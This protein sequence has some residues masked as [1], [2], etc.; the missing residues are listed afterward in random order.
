MREYQTAPAWRKLRDALPAPLIAFAKAVFAGGAVA[1]VLLLAYE[2]IELAW[3]RNVPM[4]DLHRYHQVRGVSVALLAAAVAAWQVLRG[5]P[6]LFTDTEAQRAGGGQGIQRKPDQAV[7]YA[8]WFIVMRWIAVIIAAVLVIVAVHVLDYLP[9]DVWWP[10]SFAIGALGMMNL[11]YTVALRL[12]RAAG[13]LLMAQV[14]GDLLVLTVLLHLSGGVEN[15]LSGVMLFHVIIAGIVLQR[16][17]CYMVASVASAL[18]ALLVFA[19]GIALIPHYTLAVFPHYAGEETGGHVIHAAHDAAYALS[20][21]GLQTAMM[22]LTAYFAT[23]MTE[24]LRRGERQLELFADRV[25]AQ[26]QL[27]ERALETTGTALCVCD[28]D[29]RPTWTNERWRALW[30]DDDAG[31]CWATLPAGAD[32][33]RRTL[34]DGKHR[35][36]E[37]GLPQ[38]TGG[39]SGDAGA[40]RRRQSTDT[41]HYLLT[42]APLV[43][44][45]GRITL[46]VALAR[47]ITEQK[48]IQDRILRT[49]KL[50]A[51]GEL[52]GKV[53]HEVNNPIAIISAKAR[54]LLSDHAPDLSPRTAD[55]LRKMT[56]L[57]DRVARIAQGL[58][59]YCR[60]SPGPVAPLD[61]RIPIRKALAIVEPSASAAGIEIVE[62]LP[63]TLPA[64]LV[65]CGEMEQVFL[66]LFVNAL[67][68]MPGGGRLT[69]SARAAGSAGEEP[70][71]LTVEV[72]DTGCGI[73]RDI[74]Q[75][76]F[77]PFLTTKPDGKGTGLG[78]SICLGLVRSNG[79]TIE[80][81]SEPGHGTR[82]LL[83]LPLAPAP[84]AHAIHV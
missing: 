47:E 83:Q 36:T 45:D 48:R 37:I 82:V 52:A 50:A 61:A 17:H 75:R 7:R 26:T 53:A 8:Q 84:R 30:P 21:T 18:F 2:L 40:R 22:F 63:A 42:T 3:L 79:G 54:L 55:E 60:P 5:S 44:K 11:G 64:A 12:W 59:S 6:A 14:Y 73:P 77:E 27:L 74:R 65:N 4:A 68:A 10:L 33:A 39:G 41:R 51:I 67:D 81:E 71:T 29:L 1:G 15:P 35:V 49:E 76:V 43:D 69:I 56:E 24:Q 58:L 72:A 57:C 19:E 20:R 78:L 13:A 34:A 32:Q 38:R 80:L 66:N 16:R 25:L 28:V 23:T 31:G 70:P 62:Q 9:A 46:L